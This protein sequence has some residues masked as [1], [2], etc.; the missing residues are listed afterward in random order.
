MTWKPS[1]KKLRHV[2][3]VKI[4]ANM[5][6]KPTKDALAEYMIQKIAAQAENESRKLL[7]YITAIYRV[8]AAGNPEQFGT[9]VFL[10]VGDQYF[11]V[12]AAHVLDDN[13][14]STLYI[15]SNQSGNLVILEGASFKS[16][17][18]GED[19]N[20]DRT[21]VGVVVLKSDLVDE[22][23][24]DSFLPAAM[25]DVDDIGKQGDIYIAMGYPAQKNGKVDLVKK[26]FKRRPASYTANIL[27]DEK[28]A[29]IGVHRGSH[30]LLSFKKRHSRD[31]T[32]K[33]I[34]APDPYGMSGGPLWRFDIYT[35]QQPTSRLV[36]ILI[37]WRDEVAG[38][39]AVRVPIVLAGIAHQFP[40]LGDC[41]PKITTV[42]ISVKMPDSPGSTSA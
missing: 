31:T 14:D 17:A 28:L 21:D 36:G 16:V 30:L 39:L 8:D 13:K 29:A 15:P 27:P 26:N 24:R 6:K 23:G 2:K 35:G 32:G 10:N 12:T 18:D 5:A 11:L 19:R 25:T 22:I 42:S 3:R 4:H 38:I 1:A 20:N 7:K 40:K 9:G 41:I 33:D 37:E 34:T